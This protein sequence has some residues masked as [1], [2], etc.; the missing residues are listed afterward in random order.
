LPPARAVDT[1]EGVRPLEIASLLAL[2]I[3]LATHALR[4]STRHAR[5]LV[6]GAPVA[7]LAAQALVEGPRWQLAPAYLVTL[8]GVLVALRHRAEPPQLGKLHAALRVV[9]AALALLLATALPVILPVPSIPAPDGPHL[10]GTVTFMLEDLRRDDADAPGGHRRLM[11]QAWYPADPAAARLPRAPLLPEMQHIGP[12]LAHRLGVPPLL[13]HHFALALG[14]ARE[15]APFDP[16]LALAPLVI[17]SHGLGV[18]RA[19]GTSTAEEL[20]SNGYVVLAVDHTHDAAAVAFPDGT[21]TLGD[22]RVPPGA[23]DEEEARLKAGWALIRAADIRFL[24]D[25]MSG[26]AAPFPP[27]LAGH[28]DMR[29]VGVVGHSLGGSA[30]IEA[31]RTD[32][33]IAACAD[34]DGTLY[35]EARSASLGQP[36]LRTESEPAGP[37]GE[38]SLA[39]AKLLADFDARVQGSTCLLHVEGS[40]HGDFTDL[41]SASPLL[42]YLNPIVAKE[43]RLHTLRGTN[44]ALVAFFDAAVRG[45]R[46]AWARVT[47]PRPRFRTT[48]ARLPSP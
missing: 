46:T 38:R 26:A 4:F 40:R 13:L 34:L 48:C 10:V 43:G 45:D 39:R 33:R 9:I 32:P 12:A 31:C 37:P 24:L 7:V 23:S 36:F 41:G 8:I 16:T 1:K 15:G 2:A 20:A 47:A 25:E 35:G 18:T 3:A 19:A 29:S 5:R 22:Y 28:V 21:V 6:W 42:P 44:E 27:V 17:A 30:I 11:V 14:H